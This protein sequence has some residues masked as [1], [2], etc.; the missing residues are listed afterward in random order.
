[1]FDVYRYDFKLKVTCSPLPFPE[2]DEYLSDIQ[3]YNTSTLLLKKG[4]W[5]FICQVGD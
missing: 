3:D 2:R 5:V 4:L 1:M